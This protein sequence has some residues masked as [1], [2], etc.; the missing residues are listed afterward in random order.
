MMSNLFILTVV[1]LFSNL[2]TKKKLESLIGFPKICF[3]AH[4]FVTERGNEKE[5]AMI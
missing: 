3:F 1:I 2:L 4:L 5:K